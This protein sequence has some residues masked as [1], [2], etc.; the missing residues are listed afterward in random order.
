MRGREQVFLENTT[1]R[2]RLFAQSQA[3]DVKLR[4]K[5][6][7]SMIFPF[8]L[9]NQTASLADTKQDLLGRCV[10]TGL[11]SVR[12]VAKFMYSVVL[13]SAYTCQLE[14]TVKCPKVGMSVI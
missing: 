5:K 10:S 7:T 2:Q 13:E 6:I 11:L 12:V 9:S 3:I 8:K 4:A 1:S 14:C